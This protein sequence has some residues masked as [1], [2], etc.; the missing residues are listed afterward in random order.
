MTKAND[1]GEADDG[2]DAELEELAAIDD[3][4]E[5]R[6]ALGRSLRTRGAFEGYRAALSVARDKRAPAP[7]RATA[8]VALLRA[9]NL[10]AKSDDGG[11]PK[12][13]YEMSLDEL[14][15]EIERLRR[16]RTGEAAPAKPRSKRDRGVFG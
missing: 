7:A 1:E 6:E 9:A 14:D 8:S 15:R 10:F 12:Q 13:P 16:A 3:E 2:L 11:A 4:V 5:F